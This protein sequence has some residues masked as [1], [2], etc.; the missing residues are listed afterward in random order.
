MLYL[1]VVDIRWHGFS[2]EVRANGP[3]LEVKVQSSGVLVRH[4]REERGGGIPQLLIA[5][6][7]HTVRRQSTLFFFFKCI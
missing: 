5:E 2:E 3:S 4:Y 1:V 7:C 6:F